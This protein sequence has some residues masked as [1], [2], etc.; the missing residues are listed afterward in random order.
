MGE[1]GLEQR[2]H[3]QLRP[4]QDQRIGR[5]F[6]KV[7][8]WQAGQRMAGRHDGAQRETR[9]HA[10]AQA[11]VAADGEADAKVRLA[12]DHGLGGLFG[13]ADAH[14]DLDGGVAP[15]HL[16]QHGGH[17]VGIEP[18]HGRHA[19]RAAPHAAQQL[20]LGGQALLVLQH[21]N[22]VAREHLAGRGQAQAGS[23]ALEQRAADLFLELQQLA[24]D[25]RRGHVQP[26]RGLAD[27]AAAADHVE[28]LDG[29][30]VDVHAR[31]EHAPCQH[32]GAARASGSPPSLPISGRRGSGCTPPAPS[33][34]RAHPCGCGPGPG[35][36]C[37]RRQSASP[38]RRPARRRPCAS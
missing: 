4:G 1:H 34:S 5:A 18:F 13:A 14:V 25:G 30:G 9:H 36:A 11:V 29:A 26:P 8:V 31:I 28:I 3:R 22:H 35:T 12:I 15:V 10:L 27:G 24:V 7:H 19:E 16:R 32:Q 17:Q 38:W 21:G 2:V 37:A 33:C 20:Q 6:G 23:H